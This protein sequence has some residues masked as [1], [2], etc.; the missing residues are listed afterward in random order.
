MT[1]AQEMIHC[2]DK[3]CPLSQKAKYLIDTANQNGGRDN[4]ATVLIEPQI[5]EV[6]LC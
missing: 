6:T 1:S 5:S 3:E 4:I 2:L